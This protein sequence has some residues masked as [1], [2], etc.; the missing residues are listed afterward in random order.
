MSAQGIALTVLVIAV[1]LKC[2]P[3]TEF[4]QAFGVYRI[5][6]YDLTTPEVPDAID[7]ARPAVAL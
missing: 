5:R 7:T 2:W 6:P 1:L 3:T 4:G